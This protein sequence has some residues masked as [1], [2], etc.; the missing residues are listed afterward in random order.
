MGSWIRGATMIGLLLLILSVLTQM[1]EQCGPE[2]TTPAPPPT[3]PPPTPPPPKNCEWAEWSVWSPCSATCGGGKHGRTRGIK[4]EPECGGTACMGLDNHQTQDCNTDPCDTCSSDEALINNK[5]VA[6]VCQTS[7]AQKMIQQLP[8]ALACG[9]GDVASVDCVFRAFNITSTGDAVQ[10][11]DNLDIELGLG[12]DPSKEEL[13]TAS[14]D[15]KKKILAF[16]CD[17]E[18]DGSQYCDA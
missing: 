15:I 6:D 10:K 14:G 17:C 7:L 11:A 13:A 16:A 3:P 18:G 4:Q 12:E 2:P 5:V 8:A 9:H 1:S